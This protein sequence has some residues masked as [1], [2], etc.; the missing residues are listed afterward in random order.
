[1]GLSLFA[2]RK[3]K[4]KTF[5]PLTLEMGSWLWVKKNLRQLFSLHVLF[6]P[7][8]EHRLNRVLRKHTVWLEFLMH[9]AAGHDNWMLNGPSRLRMLNAVLHAGTGHE[10]LG[11]TAR[12]DA[13]IAPLG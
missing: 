11:A 4:S 12:P 5:L 3:N 2:N 10:H 13:R 1:M 6:N 9:V 8:V 7:I